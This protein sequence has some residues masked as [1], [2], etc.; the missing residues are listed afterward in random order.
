MV[1]SEVL[2][3]SA[4]CFFVIFCFVIEQAK[5]IEPAAMDGDVL[6]STR[7]LKIAFIAINSE[8]CFI[9]VSIGRLEQYLSMKSIGFDDSD[10]KIS[11]VLLGL[12][13]RQFSLNF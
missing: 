11:S 1:T 10:L 6:S 8:I 13:R 4:T 7:L 12:A 5:K 9:L 3:A 2:H